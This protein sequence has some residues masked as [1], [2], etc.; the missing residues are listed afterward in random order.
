MAE[1][2]QRELLLL[3]F[4]SVSLSGVFCFSELFFIK[5]PHDVTVM[6]KEA[7]VLECQ[8][9]GES[10]IDVRWL[11][12][13]VKVTESE[14]MYLLSN[15]SLYFSEVE[16]RRADRSDEGSYQCLAHNKYG[17]I[18]SQKARLTIASV[19]CFSELFF[20]KEPHDVTVMRK[21]A[22]VLECQ[23][24][25]ESPIDVRW[26]KNGVK[27]TESERMYL[28]SNGSLYF[29][30]VENRRADRSDEGSYQC[31]AHNKYGAILSQKARLTIASEYLLCDGQCCM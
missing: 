8:A 14:R 17:A 11:K 6:R 3:F 15:G 30:E 23:A 24:R 27:V 2:L 5:E 25:G 10:P 7:V 9:R 16:N 19:F 4:V 13:G 12:N 28:L 21:E 1:F 31:L 29:S 18:L 20:I 26:L 22:V